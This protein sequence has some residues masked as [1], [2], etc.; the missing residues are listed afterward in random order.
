MDDNLKLAIAGGL[1]IIL[2]GGVIT[3]ACHLDKENAF[4]DKMFDKG[5]VK[6]EGKFVRLEER[7]P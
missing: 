5:W 7:K 2:L 3:F 1:F 6:I 4:R